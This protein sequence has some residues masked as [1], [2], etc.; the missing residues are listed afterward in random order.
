MEKKEKFIEITLHIFNLL[1]LCV[2]ISLS[3]FGFIFITVLKYE[4]SF[5]SF[6]IHFFTITILIIGVV[7]VGLFILGLVVLIT[8]NSLGVAIFTVGLIFC[9]ILLLS[10]GIWS[11]TVS[12]NEKFITRIYNE[13]NQSMILFNETDLKSLNTQRV[14]LLQS[15]FK[16]C[17]LNNYM[18]WKTN[19]KL[20]KNSI[21]KKD[22]LLN[23]D[24]VPFD[25]PDS[26]CIES[27]INCGKG[28]VSNRTVFTNGCFSIF[29]EYLTIRIRVI[30]ITAIGFAVV[31][32][33][34]ILYLIYTGIT[35]EGKYNMIESK[36]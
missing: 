20:N 5:S 2:G 13:I 32:F 10:L 26:C 14:N 11:H 35:T 12:T 16:C 33:V 6:L 7:I 19:Q 17:G 30:S 8:E 1:S 24:Q 3:L 15:K 31:S 27:E 22:F 18:E 36:N 34:N 23:K 25:L 28:Y 9:S 4:N 29:Q 21:L